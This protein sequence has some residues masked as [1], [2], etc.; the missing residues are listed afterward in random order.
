M[1]IY[2]ETDLEGASGVHCWEQVADRTRPEYQEARGFL[3]SDLNAAIEGAFRAGATEITVSDGHGAGGLI[4]G[5]MDP[6]ASLQSA[7]GLPLD[8]TYGAAAIIGQHAMAG[9]PRAFL[10]HTQ[11]SRNWY[12]YSL[13]GRRMGELGQFA[14]RSGAYNIPLIFVSGDYALCREAEDLIPG[15]TAV[16]V[17]K[18]NVSNRGTCLPLEETRLLIRDGMERAVRNISKIK[19]LKP[20]FPAEVRLTLTRTSLA[21]EVETFI[22]KHHFPGERVGEATF[23]MMAPGPQEIM[24]KTWEGDL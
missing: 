9:T 12:E 13:G 5:Q 3:M 11:D 16:S 21:D 4:P 19:P 22:K 2:I 20:E 8:T 6:R 7:K 23:R 24:F 15:L 17:K 1:K 10:D 14:V 18:A